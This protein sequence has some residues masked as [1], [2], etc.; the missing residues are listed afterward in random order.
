MSEVRFGPYIVGATLGTGA[1]ATVKRAVHQDTKVTVA[2]KIIPR[3]V[4]EGIAVGSASQSGAAAATTSPPTPATSASTASSV[5]NRAAEKIIREVKVLRLLNHPHI[6]RLFDVIL[7]KTEI[8]LVLEFAAGGELFD[9]LAKLGRMTEAHARTLFQQMISAIDYSHRFSVAHRDLKPENIM[10]DDPSKPRAIK[11]GDFG[12][13]GTMTDGYFFDSACGTPNYAAPEVILGKLYRGEEADAWGCGVVLYTM[14]SGRLPFD[15]DNPQLLV[16]KIREARF[17]MPKVSPEAQDLLRRTICPDPLM[18]A[19]VQQ[20]MSHP[21]V[22]TSYPRYLSIFQCAVDRQLESA[23]GSH[24]DAALLPFAAAAADCLLQIGGAVI[25]GG[26]GG[27][28]A[29][30]GSSGGPPSNGVMSVVFSP[31]G[32][33]GCLAPTAGSIAD[34]TPTS[35]LQRFQQDTSAVT[36]SSSQRILSPNASQRRLTSSVP[37]GRPSLEQSIVLQLS[38]VYGQNP[39]TVKKRI[40]DAFIARQLLNN[41]DLNRIGQRSF[42]I[43]G[44]TNSSGTPQDTHEVFIAYQL[45]LEVKRASILEVVSNQVNADAVVNAAAAHGRSPSMAALGTSTE[46]VGAPFGGA[47]STFLMAG[48][49]GAMRQQSL[50]LGRSVGGGGMGAPSGMHAPQQWG[51][52]GSMSLTSSSYMMGRSAAAGSMFLGY[53]SSGGAHGLGVGSAAGAGYS[54]GSPQTSSLRGGPTFQSTN[55][56]TPNSVGNRASANVPPSMPHIEFPL[57][58]IGMQLYNHAVVPPACAGSPLATMGVIAALTMGERRRLV[59]N[60]QG[61]ME[62]SSAGDTPTPTSSAHH[63][64]PPAAAH[65]DEQHRGRSTTPPHCDTTPPHGSSAVL[66]VDPHDAISN[67]PSFGGAPSSSVVATH[68]GSS[69]HLRPAP[70]APSVVTVQDHLCGTHRLGIMTDDTTAPLLLSVL[71]EALKERDFVWRCPRAFRI[72]AVK[73]RPTILLID[74]PSGGDVGT[75]A[76]AV[77]VRLS[78]VIYR[79]ATEVSGKYLVDVVIAR[80]LQSLGALM[81]AG[82]LLA[83]VVSKLDQRHQQLQQ[84]QQA[85]LAAMRNAWYGRAGEGRARGPYPPSPPFDKSGAQRFLVDGQTE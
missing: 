12:L 22:Q 47:P 35:S 5:P 33:N 8:V 10:L 63:T 85:R 14:L 54:L 3:K 45:F 1:F 43:D 62:T 4:F 17:T 67:A 44:I 50:G 32:R 52:L 59:S 24:F 19:T 79:V 25:G 20:I 56:P 36:P 21:W 73:H 11:M 9:Y 80:D 15:E 77:G 72:D 70:L 69:Y 18:R 51:A 81:E 41:A 64:P 30:D 74:G 66:H 57:H 16:R 6:M 46:A 23:D 31:A 29:S 68:D 84:Q 26:E 75:G 27:G 39:E 82:L 28:G 65:D 53:S 7:T 38:K 61:A 42:D 58:A 60:V 2:L 83:T 13:C 78:L 40:T 76:Y 34:L 49:I 48:S 55:T 37:I 71:Y